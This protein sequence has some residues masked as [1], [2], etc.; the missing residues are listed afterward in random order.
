MK[1]CLRSWSLGL[2]LVCL[3]ANLG[4]AGGADSPANQAFD[5][6]RSDL[7]SSWTGQLD[8]VTI[9]LPAKA[10]A[11]TL[12]SQLAYILINKDGAALQPGSRQYER[13]WIRDGSMMA[14]VL[15]RM[16]HP[17][18]VRDF[19]DWYAH[20]L[21][22]EGKVPPS[23]RADDPLDAGPGSGIEWD[24]QGAYVYLIMEY[25]RFT[26]DR[27][28]LARHFESIRRALQFLVVLR[29]QTLVPD[30]LKDE[31]SR[32]RFVGILPKSFSHEGYYPEMHSYW[33]DFWALK[34]WK[35][36]KAAAE[37]L[38]DT[39]T[40]A[41]A[42]QQYLLLRESVRRSIEA[43][44]ACKKI[45]WIPGC[46]EK[47]DFDPTSTAIV[48]FPCEEADWL[49]QDILRGTFDRYYGDVCERLKPDWKGSFTPY[50]ARN[51]LAFVA[52]GDSERANFLLEYLMGCRQPPAWNHL[53]EVVLGDPR[54]GSYIGDM[55][56]TWAGASLVNAVLAM[57]VRESGD[58]LILFDGV[59]E[60]W[61]RGGHGIR[62]GNMPTYFGTLS[63]TARMA[64]KTLHIQLGGDAA[65]P[66]GFDIRW[67]VSGVPS[68]VVV[69]GRKRADFNS[70]SC[71]MPAGAREIT[72]QW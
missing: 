8:R 52:L 66:G 54:V 53:A 23:F 10:V 55:P 46:A 13:S 30:Y 65:P 50:E 16:G 44:I 67:P 15:L 7:Q 14:P 32:E 64:G 41:W 39:N 51:I 9:D 48:F 12:K 4:V 60:S 43:T 38:G 37:V 56:H 68:T 63:V 24:G 57:L 70:S 25:Y 71:K 11:D 31:P 22:P 5:D 45:N 3:E 18:D 58:R 20:F 40:V 69:D 62:L 61:F 34:G 35:D 33:D 59:A 1:Q 17:E 49:P 2:V 29:E 21:T 27:E 42:D 72:V 26:H 19:I 6:R 28:F 36:G 47:G